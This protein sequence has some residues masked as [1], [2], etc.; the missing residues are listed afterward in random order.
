VQ[1]K[2]LRLGKV[3]TT[4]NCTISMKK[5]FLLTGAAYVGP[6]LYRSV[7]HDVT[8]DDVCP[9]DA[10]W[11]LGQVHLSLAFGPVDVVVI[12]R[13]VS[14]QIGARLLGGEE[15]RADDRSLV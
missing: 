6:V 4:M 12:V 13:D 2:Q 8:L 15:P 11:F 7:A 14:D 10:A 3:P 1:E 9:R 5:S